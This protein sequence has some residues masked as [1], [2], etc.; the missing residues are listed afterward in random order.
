MEQKHLSELLEKNIVV[1][2][3]QRE[4]V[5]GSRPEIYSQ[6][7]D[8]LKGAEARNVKLGFLYSYSRNGEEYI[9]DGQQRF[10]TLVLLLYYLSLKNPDNTENFRRRL[11]TD[12]PNMAFTYRVRTYTEQF[13]KDLF[14]SG[15]CSKKD[16]LDSKWY[17]RYYDNDLTI[18][19]MIEFLDYLDS[20]GFEYGY[21]DL[22]NVSFW[23]YPVDRTSMGEEL[24]I[25][26][27]SRGKA[28]DSA[29]HLK[30]LLMKKATDKQRNWGKEWDNW[31]E[32]FFSILGGRDIGCIN[33]AMNNFI[34]LVWELE[35]CRE[36]NAL[37]PTKAKDDI[38]LD[39]IQCYFKALRILDESE[40]KH[41]INRLFGDDVNGKK[42]ANMML[43]KA[44]IC[45]CRHYGDDKYEL[46]RVY[47]RV[48][49]VLH[50][51]G[52]LNHVPLLILLKKYRE[53]HD[54]KTFYEIIL[55]NCG[56]NWNNSNIK[57]P[58]DEKECLM[59]QILQ[60]SIAGNDDEMPVSEIPTP[61]IDFFSNYTDVEYEFWKICRR[62]IKSH[63]I[64]NGDLSVLIEWSCDETGT[65]DI[66]KFRHYADVIDTVFTGKD[67]KLDGGHEIDI[68][69][70]AIIFGIR[71]YHPVARGSYRTF[72]W[73]WSDWSRLIS[74]NPAVFKELIDDIDDGST[75]S[76]DRYIKAHCSAV[77]KF[78]DF[79][80]DNYLLDFTHRSTA[81][82]IQYSENK[83]DWNI[84]VTGG[85]GRHTGWILHY[86]ALILKEFGGDYRASGRNSRHQIGVGNWGVWYWCD[87]WN[88]CVVMDNLQYKIDIRYDNKEKTCSLSVKGSN[89]EA[90]DLTL[91][92]FEWIEKEYT[93]IIR[94]TEF[95]AKEIKQRVLEIIKEIDCIK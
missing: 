4:Y 56:K 12:S 85:I 33:T 78:T 23:Y 88:N 95:D 60:D 90:C 74:G 28:L 81:C 61:F 52:I 89:N 48:Y 34:R 84:C 31:E 87:R 49:N 63:N 29:E 53:T 9:I 16:I 67:R 91:P 22:L 46:H 25:T 11:R 58:F 6:F 83:Q 19:S 7:L 38:D 8:T 86:N 51:R 44:L 36:H 13:M 30:P 94:Q 70:R 5:W 93:Q 92:G 47:E 41:E 77:N 62:D 75:E 1:P 59:V 35:T 10:T 69:R 82:D 55:E 39:T 76:L 73:E 21:D 79:A 40:F 37:E 18:R 68:F 54:G 57:N 17:H 14:A 50:R 3:I 27:N 42:D 26:M 65:F 72:G 45:V 80:V 64:W 15:L 32:F 24:Y 66:A 2:E 43:L 20:K 71:D